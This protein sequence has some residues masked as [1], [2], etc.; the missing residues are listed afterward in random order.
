M[1]KY[2]LPSEGRFYKANLHSHTVLSDG[3]LTPEETKALYRSMGYSIVAF[4]DHDVMIPHNELA[5]ESFLPLIGVE[6]E[7]N[8]FNSYPGR[9][10]GKTCH[11]C[12]I[13]PDADTVIQPNWNERYAYVG[14]ASASA[15][16]VKFD[17]DA[18]KLERD[19]SPEFI[20]ALVRDMRDRGFFVTY[21]HPVWSLEN[22]NDYT[23]YN[24]FSAM[25]IYNFGAVIV[26]SDAYSP[27]IYDEMLRAGCGR[28]YAV[29]ADDNHNKSTQESGGG[30]SGGG[31]VMIKAEKLEYKTIMSALKRGD[32][33]ASQGPEIHELYVED[34]MVH[35]KCSDASKIV[36]T[37][38]SRAS[39]V[40]FAK[41]GEPITE[42][43]FSIR[44]HDGYFRLTVT[45]L[46]GRNANTSGY[47]L[48]DIL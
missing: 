47:F 5:D 40:I 9:R 11:I 16:Q 34:G 14:N 25:E 27:A 1:R 29:A 48:E 17:P 42:A 12:F 23:A 28:L 41:P 46:L 36:Y 44:E 21:N 30:D 31:F 2:L 45:D 24:S 35:I 39:R 37:N 10:G 8:E 15:A 13:A 7:I 33:Y 22:Y 3:R 18:P 20:N 6:Y 38:C 32:F 26:G 43:S 19:Y 4:T